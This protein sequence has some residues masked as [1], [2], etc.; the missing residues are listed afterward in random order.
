[1]KNFL[2]FF[3]VFKKKSRFKDDHFCTNICYLSSFPKI[4]Y[5]NKSYIDILIKLFL[6]QLMVKI[7]ME[8]LYQYE[9]NV[10]V[11]FQKLNRK[12]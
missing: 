2:E 7:L 3:K 6:K 9:I 10:K 8:I 5:Q 12:I 11:K 4:Q 1:M